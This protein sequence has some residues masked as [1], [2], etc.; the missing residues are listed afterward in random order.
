MLNKKI[1]KGRNNIYHQLGQLHKLIARTL[2]HVP[3]IWG[4][5]FI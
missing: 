3:N 1:F 5:K 4:K 2:R